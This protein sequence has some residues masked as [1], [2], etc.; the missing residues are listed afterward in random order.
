MGSD[1]CEKNF[2]CHCGQLLTVTQNDKSIDWDWAELSPSNDISNDGGTLTHDPPK[3]KAVHILIPA[4]NWMRNICRIQNF[5]EKIL[6]FI[7][8]SW[9][10]LKGKLDLQKFLF[11]LDFFHMCYI[12]EMRWHVLWR[13]YVTN[14]LFKC[15]K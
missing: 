3:N 5:F 2:K 1:S 13:S 11:F 8:M 10:L 15:H 7:W 14:G 9:R 4:W 12:S 6:P